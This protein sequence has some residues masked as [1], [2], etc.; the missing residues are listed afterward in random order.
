MGPAAAPRPPRKG[1]A[2][3]PALRLVGHRD[4]PNAPRAAVLATL[5]AVAFLTFLDT[6]IVSVALADVQA[7]LQAGVASLQWVVN[8]Y[9]LAFA[10]LMLAA[11]ALGDRLGRKRVMLAGLGVFCV[12]SLLGALAPNAG[13]LIASRAIMGVGA[14]ASEPGTLSV[15]R[16]VYPGRSERARALGVWASVA[17]LALALGPVIGGLLVGVSGWRGVF[18]FNLAA[19]VVVLLVALAVVPESADPRAAR[20]DVAG[21]V[22]GPLALAAAI[23]A[24]ILGETHGYRSPGIIALFCVAGAAFALSVMVERR[25]PAPMIELRHFAN[26]AFSGA[27][28]VAFAA[29]FGIFSIFFFTALY[30][31]VVVG[32]S[33]YRMAALF[34]PMAATLIVGSFS[35]GRW[36]ARSGPRLPTATGCAAA[37]LGIVLADAALRGQQPGFLALAA[38]LMLAGLGFG[39]VV[40]PATSVALATVPPEQSGMAAAA[41]TTSRELGTLLGVAV[42]GSLVNGQLASG[43]SHRLAALGVPAAFRGL[44]INGVETGQVPKGSTASGISA[45]YGPLVAKVIGAA[46]AAFRGGLSVA[47]IVASIVILAAGLIAWL[48]LAPGVRY[49]AAGAE[50]ADESGPPR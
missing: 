10:S 26:A 41:T 33:G 14:A 18:W 15:L 7:T 38:P 9:A 20:W 43:L 25:A 17:G 30:L 6:T 28:A 19:G 32:Y 45:S 47:L 37:A 49:E 40:V 11:G 12:G 22:L 24:V 44:V 31:Q 2:T 13:V 48:T 34:A 42:L 4:A 3:H 1:S 8:A 46:Y 35:A 29:Y 50:P 36:V 16:H 27:L 21:F 23:F 39:I 5:A